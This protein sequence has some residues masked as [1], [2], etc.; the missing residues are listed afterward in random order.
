MFC[1]YLVVVELTSLSL[2]TLTVFYCYYYYHYYYILVLLMV[3]S[4]S[5]KKTNVPFQSLGRGVEGNERPGC[6][7]LRE[8]TVGLPANTEQL[9]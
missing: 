7:G 3:L 1:R 6:W 9:F 5:V 4:I 2:L 8:L